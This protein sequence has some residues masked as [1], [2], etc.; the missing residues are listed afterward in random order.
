MFEVHRH[1]SAMFGDVQRQQHRWWSARQSVNGNF[2]EWI[3]QPDATWKIHSTAGP[4]NHHQPQDTPKRNCQRFLS[5]HSLFNENDSSQDRT[6][7]TCL[8]GWHGLTQRRR[9]IARTAIMPDSFTKCI[10]LALQSLYIYM[11]TYCHMHITLLAKRSWACILDKCRSDWTDCRHRK[12][13]NSWECKQVRKVPFLHPSVCAFNAIRCL[14]M[15]LH[16]YS[17]LQAEHI[18]PRPAM[19]SNGSWTLIRGQDASFCSRTKI[20]DL[21]NNAGIRRNFPGI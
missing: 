1:Q 16:M 13:Q 20:T 21:Q 12:G 7:W 19:W 2:F 14:N 4:Q 11:Y 9:C 3:I 10:T 6:F 18:F 8:V 17:L 5:R 15:H